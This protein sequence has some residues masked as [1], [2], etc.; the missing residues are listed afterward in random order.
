MSDAENLL[1]TKPLM[2][3]IEISTF[4]QS[5]AIYVAQEIENNYITCHISLQRNEVR[6]IADYLQ[7]WLSAQGSQS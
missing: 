4:P 1:I 2:N 5:V 3:A 7:D 6:Q